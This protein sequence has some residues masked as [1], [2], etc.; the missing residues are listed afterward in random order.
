[1]E[2]LLGSW[3]IVAACSAK[4]L[5]LP[6]E[7]AGSGSSGGSVARAGDG[8]APPSSGGDGGMLSGAG[9]GGT[10]GTGGSGRGG[11]GGSLVPDA[12]A[13]EAGKGGGCSCPAPP[14]PERLELPCSTTVASTLFAVVERN[15]DE[16]DLDRTLGFVRRIQAP[17]GVVA[18]PIIRTA[19]A[20]YVQ[21]G[22]TASTEP[23]P[24]VRFLLF[25][26]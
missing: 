23:A 22:S 17:V 15:E 18:S 20:V 3:V 14:E 19:G 2:W 9:V 25:P 16:Y 12:S 11:S 26:R 13:Q 5:A 1:V 6:D 24:P 8:G 21:C 7:P 10:G 4:D